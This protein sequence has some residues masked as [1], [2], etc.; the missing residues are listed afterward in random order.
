[1]FIDR[2]TRR[3]ELKPF[4]TKFKTEK[5]NYTLTVIITYIIC[6]RAFFRSVVVIKVLTLVV[7]TADDLR[8]QV[9][10]WTECEKSHNVEGHIQPRHFG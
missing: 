8:I 10:I 4:F 9:G 1:M 3:L 7:N 6:V 5:L 2:R